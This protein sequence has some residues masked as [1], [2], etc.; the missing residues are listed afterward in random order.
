MCSTH[1]FL[2]L[3]LLS[4]PRMLL[5]TLV[6]LA[7]SLQVHV[8][9]TAAATPRSGG[10]VVSLDYATFEGG[11]TSGLDSFLG[12]P[13]AQPPIGNLRFRRPQPALPLPG[14]TLVSDPKPFPASTQG[15]CGNVLPL[16]ASR[17]VLA[18]HSLWKRLFPTGLTPTSHSKHRVQRV[19][20]TC[21]KGKRV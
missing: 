1:P 12:I 16:L 13:Y 15:L 10:P 18:G 14:S 4:S 6:L 5:G 2:P 9:A 17:F 11:S 3:A 21:S 20:H 7:T 19:F 8:Y